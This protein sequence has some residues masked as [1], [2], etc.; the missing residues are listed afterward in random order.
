MKIGEKGLKISIFDDLP[1][2]VPSYDLFKT[3][4]VRS[5]GYSD[6]T[7]KWKLGAQT[8]L[9]WNTLLW[10]NFG[11]VTFVHIAVTCDPDVRL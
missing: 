4:Q 8:F 9:F 7:A 5:S 3:S 1:R 10:E 2:K 6:P 11:K